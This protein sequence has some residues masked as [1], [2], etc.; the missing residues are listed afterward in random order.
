MTAD[1]GKFLQNVFNQ[2]NAGQKAID[3]KKLKAETGITERTANA[4]SSAILNKLDELD[5]LDLSTGG[6][7]KDDY[8]SGTELTAFFTFVNSNR[9]SDG[10][11]LGDILDAD[12]PQKLTTALNGGFNLDDD[13]EQIKAE[14]YRLINAVLDKVN[15]NGDSNLNIT[16]IADASGSDGSLG[17]DDEGEKIS[18]LKAN[19][20][21]VVTEEEAK[22]AVTAQ[23]AKETEAK[24]G[25]VSNEMATAI[26]KGSGTEED[27]N[28]ETWLK[29]E[30]NATILKDKLGLT[31]GLV[32]E[33]MT[34]G[35]KDA[36]SNK[37]NLK[38]ALNNLRLL[39]DQEIIKKTGTEE[40]DK[41]P[42]SLDELL[43]LKTDQFAS[44]FDKIKRDASLT[45]LLALTQKND[46]GVTGEYQAF[47][48]D[49]SINRAES[50]MKADS[51][52]NLKNYIYGNTGG[53][54][55]DWFTKNASSTV[56]ADQMT[57]LANI[58]SGDIAK[59]GKAWANFYTSTQGNNIKT[60]A[61]Q[62]LLDLDSVKNG[63]T[64]VPMEGSDNKDKASKLL[65][66][67]GNYTVTFGTDNKM[68]VKDE[69]STKYTISVKNG[70]IVWDP[71]GTG[72]LA[73]L[74]Q[75]FTT[76]TTTT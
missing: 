12:K 34:G 1:I 25:I 51:A 70:G 71:D 74:K 20:E 45:I 26:S 66:M 72:A 61:I 37:D 73:A 32:A 15:E 9:T 4:K 22:K 55:A 68:I 54:G 33:I 2:S 38:S 16:D 28:L 7:G 48:G 56:T 44:P 27:T 41:K 57:N 39:L 64:T 36:G 43:N 19:A 76:P 67:I 58:N 6:Q 59:R 3:L 23:K 21:I 50:L 65:T 8:L 46:Y 52:E 49:K 42:A 31:N 30:A 35:T 69:I 62:Y 60:F 10:K 18:N 14:N 11:F 13:D 24:N 63:N 75:I 47:T 29:T 53:P 17:T 5:S 40:A